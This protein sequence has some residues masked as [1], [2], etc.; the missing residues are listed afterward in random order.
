VTG[1]VGRAPVFRFVRRGSGILNVTGEKLTED[2]VVRSVREVVGGREMAGFTAG[3]R[4]A[5]VPCILFLMEGT[6]TREEGLAERLDEALARSNVEYASKRKSGRLGPVVLE[7][8][9]PGTYARYRAER[10]REGAP[11]GQVKDPILAVDEAALERVR[12]A[13]RLGGS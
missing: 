12:A 11:D 10:V 13:V 2:Q 7:W 6:R 5:E 9:P 8:L 1:H 3:H 4:M